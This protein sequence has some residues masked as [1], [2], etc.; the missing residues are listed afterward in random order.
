MDQGAALPSPLP[1]DVV[2]PVPWETA[3]KLGLVGVALT[4]GATVLGAVVTGLGDN[5]PW[6]LN[7]ARLFLVAFGLVIAGLAVSFRPDLWKVWGLGITTTLLAIA[8]TPA[9]WDTFRLLFTVL[10]CL[11]VLGA[12]VAGAPPKW[13]YRVL[14]VGIVFHFSGIFLATTSPPTGRYGAPW[15][16]EQ[17]YY[18]V[19]NPYLYFLH[20]RN[21][22]HFYSPEPGPAS[23]L[24]FLLKT[25]VGEETLPNGT[26]A[27]KYEYQ[28][29][30]FPKRPADIRD[31]LGLTY[32]RRLSLTEQVARPYPPLMLQES[33]ER[34]EVRER[35]YLVTLPG[36]DPQIPFHPNEQVFDQYLVPQPDITRYL[37]PSYAQH[38]IIE[39]IPQQ[40]WGKTTAKA[41]RLEHRILPVE[42]FR[43]PEGQPYHPVTYR[44]LFLGEFGFAPDPAAPGKTHIVL[45]N[46]QEPMLYWMLPVIHRSVVGA[47]TDYLDYFSAHALG[48]RVENLDQEPYASRAFDWSQLR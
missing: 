26:K 45:V 40:L 19:Y 32:Y 24:A 33:F 41:Y 1:A 11:A 28:W 44:V 43:T 46:P 12:V 36:A 16:V 9:S 42:A 15:L 14:T 8:G 39:N 21:A 37:L 30:V 17:L 18:R 3:R 20:L 23:L 35:R 47:R 25:E 27:P 31:P 48:V 4:G 38:V 29:V 6:L 34:S 13:R 5:A 7:T 10:T 22:Y 2:P